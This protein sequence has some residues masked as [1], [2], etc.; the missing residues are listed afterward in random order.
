MRAA[1]VAPIMAAPTTPAP[2]DPEEAAPVEAVAEV[3][4]IITIAA[5]AVPTVA[6]APTAAAPAA[7]ETALVALGEMAPAAQVEAAATAVIITITAAA[8]RL[9]ARTAV[10]S[11]QAMAAIVAT[12]HMAMATVQS[13]RPKSSSSTDNGS[14]AKT[15]G[16][17]FYVAPRE[18]AREST[19]VSNSIPPSDSNETIGP[20]R[21]RWR[22]T[23]RLNLTLPLEYFAPEPSARTKGQIPC[24][25]ACR[26]KSRTT[27]IASA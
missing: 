9:S 5:L 18:V 17:F 14:G 21:V 8:D 13:S 10:L 26:R 22:N 6:V 11:R 16:P 27:N 2:V 12:A 23:V 4:V 19:V 20:S 15:P 7:V 24:A 25:S 3:V 1:L